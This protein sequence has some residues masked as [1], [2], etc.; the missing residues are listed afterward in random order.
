[1]LDN[2]NATLAGNLIQ[3]SDQRL[4]TNIF[5]LDSSSS[6]AEID[7]FNPVT[8]N[9]IDPNKSSVPQFG[10]IAQQVQQIFPNLVSTTSPTALTP[11][12]TLSLNYIDLISPIVAAIQELDSELTS[13]EFDRRRLLAGD[14]I[15]DR[16]LRPSQCD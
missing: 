9:W 6:L 4:K 2:G 10:F 13:L 5:D 3:N 15:S 8:F 7:A 12:G 16:K 11:D 14:H 1:M